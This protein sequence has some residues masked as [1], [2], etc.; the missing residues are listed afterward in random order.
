M[1]HLLKIC[2]LGA[3]GIAGFSYTWVRE[4]RRKLLLEH[5]GNH[6][7]KEEFV[8]DTSMSQI[9]HLY[10][11]KNLGGNYPFEPSINFKMSG[12]EFVDNFGLDKYAPVRRGNGFG[13]FVHEYDIKPVGSAETF[14]KNGSPIRDDSNIT[15]EYDPFLRGGL[16]RVIDRWDK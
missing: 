7:R 15:F 13:Y 11:C 12:K 8:G 3:A 1:S 5:I 4:R 10:F 2:G 9:D 16:F 6:Y 14:G